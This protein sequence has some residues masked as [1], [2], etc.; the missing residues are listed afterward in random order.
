MIDLPVELLAL[1]A[2]SLAAGVDLYLTLLFIGAAPT[3]GLWELPLPGAL[4]DLDSPGVLIMVG[5]FYVAE[6]TAERFPVAALVWNAFHAVI[7][8]VSGAL[9]A[10]LLLDGQ[11]LP[12]IVF[13]VLVAGGLAS[14]AHA[15]RTGAWVLRGFTDTQHPAPLLI[16]VAEDVTVLGIV[17]LA[18]DVPL[19]AFGVAS[20]LLVVLAPLAP[21]RVRAFVYAIRLGVARIFRTLGLRRWRRAD[22]LP[23]WVV[24]AFQDDDE[25]LAHGEALRGCTAGAWRLPGAP[26]F[27]VGWVI[28]R[29]GRPLFLFR[30]RSW[31]GRRKGPRRVE[32]GAD[33][34]ASVTD[35]D[36]YRR[37]DLR[38]DGPGGLLVVGWGGPSTESLQA[39]FAG[40]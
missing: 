40:G 36:L 3:T 28:V 5:A 9:L 32:L 18:L 38:E 1:P 26:R 27:A 13:G 34:T 16:S 7:R 2:L 4:G 10:L 31:M 33:V 11:A 17:S 14:L 23:E 19:W 20:V 8:P 29:A 15:V 37:I 22:E 35:G 30:A 39:E 25:I 6:F 24:A 12:V 21:S